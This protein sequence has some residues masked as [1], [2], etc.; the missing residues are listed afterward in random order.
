MCFARDVMMSAFMLFFRC[1]SL[2]LVMMVIGLGQRVDHPTGLSSYPKVDVR[3]GAAAQL[4][5]R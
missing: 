5:I 1:T 2:G 4:A 3:C